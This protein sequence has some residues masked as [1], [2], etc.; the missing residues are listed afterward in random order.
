MFTEHT[1][2]SQ[3]K[4]ILKF[5]SSQWLA[6]SSHLC[7]LW[8]YKSRMFNA[9][10]EA[11]WHS[12]AD[13]HQL[14]LHTRFTVNEI[15]RCYKTKIANFFLLLFFH[16]IFGLADNKLPFQRISV[17]VRGERFLS[18]KFKRWLLRLNCEIFYNISA[19][20]MWLFITRFI[21]HGL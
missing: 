13:I 1:V 7:V 5:I 14:G 20:K 9:E 6:E 18:R 8:L 16:I 19:F 2:R 21:D 4:K 11:N 3:F 15:I 12:S 10:P 17:E